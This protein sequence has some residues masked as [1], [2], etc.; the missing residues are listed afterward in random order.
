MAA[1]GFKVPE[2]HLKLYSIEAGSIGT[3]AKLAMETRRGTGYYRVPSLNGLRYRGPFGHSG[4]V[5]ELEHWFTPQRLTAEFFPAGFGGLSGPQGA[6][7]G[8]EFGLRLGAQDMA[9]LLG[10]L[11]TL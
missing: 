4:S 3:D 8:H 1:P 5:V 11:R 6:V 10:Y 2:A 9:A 7:P